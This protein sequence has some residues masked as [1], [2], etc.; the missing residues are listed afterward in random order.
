[1]NRIRFSALVLALVL[2]LGGCAPQEYSRQIFAMDTF[3]S[4]TAYGK[5]G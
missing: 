3:M 1:M 4:M 2:L 5:G